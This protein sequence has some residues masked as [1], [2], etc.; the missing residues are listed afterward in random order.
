[1]V[2]GDVVD[3]FYFGEALDVSDRYCCNLDRRPA[4]QVHHDLDALF[5]LLQGGAQVDCGEPEQPEH[6]QRKGDRR[7]R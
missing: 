1:M 6:E 7:D 5:G 2:F 3:R 4:R